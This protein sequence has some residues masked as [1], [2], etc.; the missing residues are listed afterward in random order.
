MKSEGWLLCP[1]EPATTSY[2][3][4]DEPTLHSDLI[5]LTYASHLRPS[6]PWGSSFKFFRLKFCTNFS[7]LHP[8]YIPHPSHPPRYNHSN[9]VWSRIQIMKLFIMQFVPASCC[10]LPSLGP[11]PLWNVRNENNS[12]GPSD[13]TITTRL[14]IYRGEVKE[15]TTVLSE[16]A[17]YRPHCDPPISDRYNS[18]RNVVS[19]GCLPL[20]SYNLY[21]VIWRHNIPC[22]NWEVP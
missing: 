14:L 8:C 13:W 10:F 22:D 11:A 12:R 6:L 15:G 1:Q 2:H 5:S 18:E 7:S 21:D 20:Y 9:N 16:E 4:P 3:E 17:N 19:R